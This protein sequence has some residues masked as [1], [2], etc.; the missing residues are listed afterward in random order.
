MYYVHPKNSTGN[1]LPRHL[2]EKMVL[3]HSRLGLENKSARI[4]C[5]RQ[6]YFTKSCQQIWVRVN[7][8]FILFT[9][10]TS[11]V[12]EYYDALFLSYR[13]QTKCSISQFFRPNCTHSIFEP[14]KHAWAFSETVQKISKIT[15]TASRFSLLTKLAPNLQCTLK[16][17]RFNIIKTLGL[18]FVKCVTLKSV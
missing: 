2:R 17:L 14:S 18:F 1:H 9:H 15:H 13:P 16:E 11:K 10:G 7:Q 5:V 3:D 12:K 4:F 6:V 8:S